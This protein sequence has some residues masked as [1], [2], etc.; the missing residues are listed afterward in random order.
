MT[1]SSVSSYIFYSWFNLMR[2]LVT[3]ESILE[4]KIRNMQATEERLVV[5]DV[6]VL[7][8]QSILVSLNNCNA[9]F[10]CLDNPEGYDVSFVMLS[11]EHLK[12]NLI[13]IVSGY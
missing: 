6:D 5:Y 13:C 4:E 11:L 10:C 2:T 7:D 12:K 9:V 1:K 8:Y 3:G